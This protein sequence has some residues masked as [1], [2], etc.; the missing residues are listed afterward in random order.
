SFG[1][2]SAR[3]NSLPFSML[4]PSDSVRSGY[5]APFLLN[6][7]LVLNATLPVPVSTTATYVT[8]VSSQGPS[9][10][11]GKGVGLPIRSVALARPLAEFHGVRD[12]DPFGIHPAVTLAAAGLPTALY[13]TLAV[14]PESSIP[15]EQRQLDFFVHDYFRVHPNL[16][17]N[18]GVRVELSRV[19]VAN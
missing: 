14:V 2:T 11:A 16:T 18:A 17:L 9:L 5:D 12:A 3:F 7:P 13:Q 4:L 19:P 1:R 8:A 15:L 10:L 6:A